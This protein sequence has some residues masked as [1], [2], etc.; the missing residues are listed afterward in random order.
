M[1]GEIPQPNDPAEEALYDRVL[2]VA[3]T[4]GASLDV[5]T[6]ATDFLIRYVASGRA[7]WEFV[8]RVWDQTSQEFWRLVGPPGSFEIL[9][10]KAVHICLNREAT[11]EQAEALIKV[12][13]FSHGFHVSDPESEEE[14]P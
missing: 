12:V 11:P 2:K 7:S 4:P 9:Y 8:E 14:S 6:K 10:L 13:F 5:Q 3:T 1:P